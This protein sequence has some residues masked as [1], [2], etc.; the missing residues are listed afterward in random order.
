MKSK[1]ENIAEYILYLWQ[2][3][4]FVRAFPEQ[5][6]QNKELH[7]ILDML[8]ADGVWEKGH[9]QMAENALAELEDLA[10]DLWNE[11]ATFRAAMLRLK[12][13][14]NLLKAKTD[15]P[16][17]SDLRACFTLLYQVM[18]LRLQKKEISQETEMVVWQ[19][20]QTMRYLSK[21][22]KENYDA[23]RAI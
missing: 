4:D 11:E 2:M 7:E 10:D 3:E 18:M 23:E 12:P 22:Y 20:T 13:Q 1:R 5:A 16:T 14:L 19:V 21:T 6:E 8:H 15:E 9:V 17:M